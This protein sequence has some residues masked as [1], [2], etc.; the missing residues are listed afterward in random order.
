M[1]FKTEMRKVICDPIVSKP[2]EYSGRTGLRGICSQTG[3]SLNLGTGE[4]YGEELTIRMMFDDVPEIRQGD[5]I[6]IDGTDYFVV[7][8]RPQKNSGTVR[9]YYSED[10]VIA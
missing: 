6:R 8:V 4:I 3:N 7:S 2:V 5:T 10:E 1:D 9:I